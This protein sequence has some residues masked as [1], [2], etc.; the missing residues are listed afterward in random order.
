MHTMII[1]MQN[2]M[3]KCVEFH[4][5]LVGAAFWNSLFFRALECFYLLIEKL[6]YSTSKTIS[7]KLSEMKSFRKKKL[8]HY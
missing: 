6:I 5:V 4:A 1:T 7:K 3:I 2:K 8:L